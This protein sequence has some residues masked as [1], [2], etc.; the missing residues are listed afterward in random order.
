[1]RG[2]R[3]RYHDL[4][5]TGGP[6]GD[7]SRPAVRSDQE[8]SAPTDQIGACSKAS[9]EIGLSW[10]RVPRD[11]RGDLCWVVEGI[12]LKLAAA[13]RPPP[14]GIRPPVVR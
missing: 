6:C 9:E 2:S 14:L 4:A 11:E 8:P 5:S 10:R 7:R 13:E 12:D 3:R 1:M